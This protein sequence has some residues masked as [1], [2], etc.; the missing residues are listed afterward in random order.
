MQTQSDEV[1]LLDAEQLSPLP[2]RPMRAGLFGK[3]LEDA[4]QTLLQKY[5]EI[6]PGKQIDPGSDDPPRFVLLRRE[7]PLG[8]WSLDHLYVDQRAILTL[9]ETK[10]E[11]RLNLIPHNTL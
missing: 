2:A 3:T 8:G 9:V 11:V 6:I 5:P 7:M 4:L 1:F 10:L